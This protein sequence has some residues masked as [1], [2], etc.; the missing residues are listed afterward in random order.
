MRRVVLLKFFVSATLIIMLLLSL[1]SCN[2]YN[3]VSQC[4]D[5]ENVMYNNL[6][7][8]YTEHNTWSCNNEN[9]SKIG[10]VWYIPPLGV[11]EFYSDNTTS[12]D[13]IYCSRS[14]NVWIR[15]GYNYEQ[16]IFEIN[17]TDIQIVYADTF[18]GETVEYFD[19]SAKETAEFTWYPV[20]HSELKN[21]PSIFEKNGLYYIRFAAEGE[22]YLIK[23]SFL[24]ILYD[25]NIL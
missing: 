12:P 7:Y 1:T 24:K 13:F 23:D 10:W 11:S 25:N 16:E 5:T 4:N 15:E 14:R 3:K 17:D 9:L 20:A 8:I 6:K 2:G 21:N 22:A 18:S 19:F